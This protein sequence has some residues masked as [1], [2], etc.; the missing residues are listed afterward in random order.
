MPHD[1]LRPP[2][3][4]LFALFEMNSEASQLFHGCGSLLERGG[5]VRRLGDGFAGASPQGVELAGFLREEVHAATLPVWRGLAPSPLFPR[6]AASAIVPTGRESAERQQEISF[7]SRR[8][9]HG[10]DTRRR[11]QCHIT[12]KSGGGR[13]Q[14][15]HGV[16]SLPASVWEEDCPSPA[17][18]AWVT[19]SRSSDSKDA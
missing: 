14:G 1:C 8:R 19:I 12:A 7:W 11:F 9:R 17:S 18:R 3:G 13:S 2:G 4:Q 15:L 16:G 6:A 5:M 10:H